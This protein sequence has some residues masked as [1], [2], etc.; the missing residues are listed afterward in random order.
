M[1]EPFVW[2][3]FSNTTNSFFPFKLMPFGLIGW[4]VVAQPLVG[5]LG[6]SG[7]LGLAQ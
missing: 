1:I 3:N 6:Q 5:R 4:R 2:I 7:E